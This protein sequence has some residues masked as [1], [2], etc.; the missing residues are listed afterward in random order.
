M[1]NP[2]CR[3]VIAPFLIAGILVTLSGCE[4]V[5]T[6]PLKDSYP[7][8]SSARPAEPT[9]VLLPVE[10]V[11]PSGNSSYLGGGLDFISYFTIIPYQFMVDSYYADTSKTDA[12]RIATHARLNNAG[13]AVIDQ[14][15]GG[16]SQFNTRPAGDLGLNIRVREIKVDTNFSAAIPL[17]L[18][19]IF[20]YT[21]I[22]SHVA[23]DCQ[24]W[25]AGNN[26]PLWEGAADQHFGDDVD[27][28][29]AV[30][31]V[32]DQCIAQSK[33]V[34]KR[35]EL[36]T[37]R[38]QYVAQVMADAAAKQS[39]GDSM[40]ALDLY[41]KA[42]VMALEANDKEQA[43][44]AMAKQFQAFS[45]PPVLPEEAR[46]FGVQAETAI[47]NKNLVAAAD[48]Y[49]SELT[50][51]PWWPQSHFNL[52]LILAELKRNP[53]AIEEMKKYLALVPNAANARQAQDKIYAWEMH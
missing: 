18:I 16:L 7:V 24:L 15:S 3:K 22:V 42:S 2:S 30:A 17:I 47:R 33:L 19:N 10:E 1:S 50:V 40:A 5:K 36:I 41:A 44:N 11:T 46:K 49:R 23:L 9:I 35:G 6:I 14:A 13:I 25:Q 4:F 37:Q 12:V 43:F 27:V 26:T 34:E 29:D 45:Q 21:D 32:V 39:S 20:M 31:R 52:A 8:S 38:N 53:E 48:S 28:K 51:T